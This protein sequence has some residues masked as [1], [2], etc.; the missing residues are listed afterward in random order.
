MEEARFKIYLIGIKKG[1]IVSSRETREQ[2][3]E[4]KSLKCQLRHPITGER[5]GW[6]S[7]DNPDDEKSLFQAI[8]NDRKLR[9]DQGLLLMKKPPFCVITAIDN[10]AVRL[11]FYGGYRKAQLIADIR[12][13]RLQGFKLP[14][15]IDKNL[16]MV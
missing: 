3:D 5:L 8:L 13:R 9:V 12:N 4:V 11:E 7:F 16:K 6:D 15:F 1:K 14:S 10:I 2:I